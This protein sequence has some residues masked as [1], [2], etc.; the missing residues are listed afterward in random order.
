MMKKVPICA[1]GMLATLISTFAQSP[2]S[3][4]ASREIVWRLCQSAVLLS[5]AADDPYFEATFSFGCA[6]VEWDAYRRP[7]WYVRK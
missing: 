4:N 6:M 2:F 3:D 1:A 7:A 5:A